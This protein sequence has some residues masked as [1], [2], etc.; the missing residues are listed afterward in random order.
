M[1]VSPDMK[2][3]Q[4]HEMPVTEFCS[5]IKGLHG[6][7]LHLLSMSVD[8]PPGCPCGPAGIKYGKEIVPA[9][10][11]FRFPVRILLHYFII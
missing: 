9:H 11:G 2:H 3:W 6:N 4:D 10:E 8:G 5:Q 7:I 1:T